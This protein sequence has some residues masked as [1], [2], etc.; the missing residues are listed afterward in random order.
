MGEEEAGDGKHKRTKLERDQGKAESKSKSKP[1]TK[2][3]ITVPKTGKNAKF[4]EMLDQQGCVCNLHGFG[5]RFGFGQH[6]VVISNASPEA[7]LYLP[8]KCL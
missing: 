3:K 6:S 7:P 8:N 2:T 1:E 5:C 4:F